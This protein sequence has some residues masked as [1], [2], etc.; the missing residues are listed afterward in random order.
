M[1][2]SF[3]NT[4][5]TSTV[6]HTGA[7]LLHSC[8][9]QSIDAACFCQLSQASAKLFVASRRAFSSSNTSPS[10]APSPAATVSG[11]HMPGN[12]EAS[13][14][15][16]N[17]LSVLQVASRR[18]LSFGHSNGVID[19]R[20]KDLGLHIGLGIKELFCPVGEPHVKPKIA[21]VARCDAAGLHVGPMPQLLIR[22][23][24]CAL[25]H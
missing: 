15:C 18:H 24:E 13:W 11:I 22:T 4:A 10:G 23:L 12:G 14:T 9:R 7:C 16:R 3:L 5:S 25:R 20:I 6:A 19:E 2:R 21:L 1:P 8:C 17:G